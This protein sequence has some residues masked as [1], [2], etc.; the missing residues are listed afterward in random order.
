M[1]LIFL[2]RDALQV[3]TTL[4]N[5][6]QGSYS[7]DPH[8]VRCICNVKLPL[9]TE[10]ET[11]VTFVNRDGKTGNYVNTAPAKQYIAI[12]PFFCTIAGQ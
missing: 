7:I 9:N 1:Q 4:Q 11:T 5:T 2:L 8:E 12:A 6:K 10:L 3:S